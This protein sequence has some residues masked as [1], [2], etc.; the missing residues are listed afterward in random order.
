MYKADESIIMELFWGKHTQEAEGSERLSMLRRALKVPG[1]LYTLG[2][3]GDKNISE[4]WRISFHML[5]IG[6]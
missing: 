2:Y 4:I 1:M 3:C 5:Q 6:Y